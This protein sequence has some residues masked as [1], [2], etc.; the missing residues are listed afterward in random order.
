MQ[1]Q[2][3]NIFQPKAERVRTNDSKIAGLDERSTQA[4]EIAVHSSIISSPINRNIN[5]TQI[6]HNVVTPESNLKNN[7]L[8]L[9]MSEYVDQTQ[10]QFLELR[11]SHQRMK[12]LTACMDKIVKTLQEGHAQLRKA[13]EETNKRLNQVIEKQNHSK[14]DRNCMDQDINK[15]FS[16][17]HNMRPQPQGHVMQDPYNQKEIKPDA[18]LVNKGRSP[19]Q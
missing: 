14:S 12:T 16:V 15:L 3:Q 13:S 10:T 1:G 2:E 6:E 11:A 8:W 9:Q 19:S 5:P 7:A 17:Y 4:P 18:I